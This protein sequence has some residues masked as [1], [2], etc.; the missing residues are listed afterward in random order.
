LKHNQN[1]SPSF[2]I[3][4]WFEFN[5]TVATLL[6]SYWDRKMSYKYLKTSQQNTW[7]EEWRIESVENTAE[8]RLI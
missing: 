6:G 5:V 8:F 1:K 3:Y 7:C 4:I 2:W